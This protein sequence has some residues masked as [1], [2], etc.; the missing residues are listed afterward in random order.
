MAFVCLL[1]YWICLPIPP[2]KNDSVHVKPVVWE[3]YVVLFAKNNKKGLLHVYIPTNLLTLLLRPL[4]V[5]PLLFTEPFTLKSFS[6][7]SQKK[8]QVSLYIK[9][10]TNT[11][12]TW[13]T[14]TFTERKNILN[15]WRLIPTVFEFK[16]HRKWYKA[17]KR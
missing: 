4:Q 8:P 5:K 9:V 17:M 1:R 3:R 15:Y 16:V 12:L 13:S 14:L 7:I 2:L 11:R 6:Q 10:L